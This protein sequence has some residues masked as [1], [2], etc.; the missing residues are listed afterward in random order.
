MN[1][2]FKV[3]E[4]RIGAHTYK[5]TQLDAVTGRRTFFRLTK[6]AGPAMARLYTGGKPLDERISTALQELLQNLTEADVDHFCDT[7]A[8]VTEVSGGQYSKAAPQL[9]S[10]F[11]THFAGDYMAMVQWLGFCVQIN[12]RSFFEQAALGLANLA[13]SASTSPTAPTGSSGD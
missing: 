1:A 11:I 7:F 4:K 10:V 12:F 8:A 13:A 5:V 6:A 9:D 2:P 3:E